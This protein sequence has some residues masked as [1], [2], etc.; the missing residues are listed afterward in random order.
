M[1]CALCGLY[2][3]L[4]NSCTSVVYCS[5]VCCTCML[6]HYC[7]RDSLLKMASELELLWMR[8]FSVS[9]KDPR[10]TFILQTVF[11]FSLVLAFEA[12][13][14]LDTNMRFEN[15]SWQL[16]ISVASGELP[17]INI[18]EHIVAGQC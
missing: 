14:D 2:L 3:F 8:H 9:V 15:C 10:S 13:L 18:F 12:Y 11:S 6:L 17:T 4:F 7:T 5:V 1:L 16:D